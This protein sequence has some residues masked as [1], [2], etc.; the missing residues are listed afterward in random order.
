MLYTI[1][2]AHFRA[3][4]GISASMKRIAYANTQNMH[5]KCNTIGY[6][7]RLSMF[8]TSYFRFSLRIFV[9]PTIHHVRSLRL[10]FWTYL[11]QASISERSVKIKYLVRL[12]LY[13]LSQ[14]R[15]HAK[16]IL[17]PRTNPAVHMTTIILAAKPRRNA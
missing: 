16:I 7:I 17:A 15:S 2:H 5:S 4:L 11:F 8:T 12:I 13:R 1:I 3:Q 10:R 14:N 9:V 6:F